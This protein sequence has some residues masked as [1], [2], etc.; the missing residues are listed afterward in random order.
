MDKKT[1]ETYDQN[2]G[3]FKKAHEGQNPL[4]LYELC[5]AFFKKGAP[6]AD[7]G[8][9]IGRDTAWLNKNDYPAEGFDA[10][11]GMLKVA[12]QA[13][14]TIKFKAVSIPA[15]EFDSNFENLF[16]CAVLM[17]IP[18]SSLVA[19]VISL[20]KSLTPNGRLVLSYRSGQGETDGRLFETY[21]PG[22]IAQLFESLGGKVLLIEKDG[23]WEN[24][25]IEKQ[26][27]NR[28]EGIQLIQD[29]ITTDR[30]VATYK[31]ALI[32]ALCEIS[33]YEAHT[34]TWYREGDMV[35]VPMRRIAARWVLYYLPLVKGGLK[36]TTSSKMA[37]EDQLAELPYNPADM[38][39]LKN[40]LDEINTKEI[41]SLIRKV[42]DTI[43]KGPVEHSGGSELEIFKFITSLDASVYPELNHSENGMVTV[44]L[45]LWRDI[46]LFSHWIEDSLSIQW[47]ELSTKIN[48]DGK[49]GYHLDL[50]TKSVQIDERSTRDIRK[51]LN[52]KNVECVWTG[53]K[54][55]TF[56]V[57]HMIPWTIW[58][59]N[60]LWN[61]L[62][63][64][65]KV[66]NQKRD[67]LPDPS[68]IKKRY[69]S[70]KRYWEIYET[71]LP[72][73][74][75]QQIQKGLGVNGSSRSESIEALE[76]T[77]ARLK[78]TQGGTYWK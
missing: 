24:L 28:R 23:I 13:Y 30:K 62:P 51:L 17:H 44:P 21:H 70:I 46:N 49:F 53:K 66:N 40:A 11:E 26:D 67:M 54:L 25:V 2:A 20:L 68:I 52:G 63:T 48:K 10:S 57:D 69:D 15:L 12:K 8:C 39:L 73:L 42:S 55:E 59:N 78:I 38:I 6:T 31:F 58:R 1:V 34:V 7:I 27:L 9:G 47:A 14:P 41:S 35:L 60:D 4:R 45:S 43:R 75:S 3:D 61:L 37:F 5:K 29:I 65:P 77:L 71:A 76:H 32:R 56:D 18:R 36:Q 74:F 33:R 16:C 72:N 22:Q 64:D 50:I 19:S